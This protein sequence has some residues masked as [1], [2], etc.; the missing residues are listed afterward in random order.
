MTWIHYSK[1]FFLHTTRGFISTVNLS[2]LASSC[3]Q[4]VAHNR[5][6]SPTYAA[7][8]LTVLDSAAIYLILS[9]GLVPP[10]ISVLGTLNPH[11]QTLQGVLQVPVVSVG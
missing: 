11:P 2:V 3:F 7:Q 5:I 8:R 6:E 9:T 10:R 1:L 4:A